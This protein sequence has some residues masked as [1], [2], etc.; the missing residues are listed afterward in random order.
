VLN[1]LETLEP[2]VEIDPRTMERARAPLQ[3]MMDIGRGD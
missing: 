1:A 3:R 2:V